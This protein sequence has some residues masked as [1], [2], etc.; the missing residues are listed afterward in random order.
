[1]GC[2][3]AG[4]VGRVTKLYSIIRLNRIKSE[5][6]VWILTQLN[7]IHR[8]FLIDIY[9]MFSIAATEYN[10]VLRYIEYAKEFIYH[11]ADIKEVKYEIEVHCFK[12]NKN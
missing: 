3:R 12:M 2:G 10:R 1:M 8:I 5:K 4:T 7:H 6:L 9:G 11:K